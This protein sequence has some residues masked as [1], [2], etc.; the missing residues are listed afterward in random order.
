MSVSFDSSVGFVAG[1]CSCRLN[2]LL[3]ISQS[4]GTT[5]LFSQGTLFYGVNWLQTLKK[6]QRHAFLT[7]LLVFFQSQLL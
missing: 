6:Y 1:Y 7:E 3:Q 5:T 2:S 4:S